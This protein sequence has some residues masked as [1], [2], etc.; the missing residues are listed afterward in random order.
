MNL[1]RFNCFSV[2]TASVRSNSQSV[3]IHRFAFFLSP[4]GTVVEEL[5]ASKD[6]SLFIFK[7]EKLNYDIKR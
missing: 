1:V 7:K 5:D 3:K 4:A 2:S 6:C